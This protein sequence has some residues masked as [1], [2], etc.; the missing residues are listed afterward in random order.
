MA[1]NRNT[2]T[3]KN[4]AGR[5]TV[6]VAEEVVAV[7]A[8]LAA[9]EVKG[10]ASIAGGITGKIL[11]RKGIKALSRGVHVDVKENAVTVDLVLELDY[12]FS[13]PEVGT[14]VQE[15]VKST[16]E[17]MTGLHVDNINISV[18]DVAVDD[19]EQ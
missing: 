3:L 1:E 13:I 6:K 5:G 4:D 14:E 9:T 7:I 17:T 19:G 15:K 8:G 12:G 18:A 11:A 10:V 2:Y 16:I